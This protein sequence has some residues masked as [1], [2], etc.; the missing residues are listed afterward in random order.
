MTNSVRFSV[1]GPMRAWRDDVAVDL[2]SPQQRAVLA[3]LLFR[4]G[5]PVTLDELVTAVWDQEP[6]RAAVGTARTYIHR[7]R[8]VLEADP[9]NPTVLRSL[10]GGY[11]M[12][13]GTLDLN[14]F[15][16]WVDTAAAAEQTGRAGEAAEALD[17]ALALWHGPALAGVPGRY[18]E[19]QR[20]R[21][22]EVRLIT[23]ERRLELAIT[24]GHYRDAVPELAALV[25][26]DPFRERPRHLL[27]LALAGSGRR[28]EALAVFRD[29]R[30]LLADELGI[31]PGRALQR[32]HRDIL[33]GSEPVT[34]TRTPAETTE[35][36]W[37]SRHRRAPVPPRASLATSG[38]RAAYARARYRR[39]FEQARSGPGRVTCS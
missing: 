8:R 34:P 31:E 33:D 6:P 28:A 3:A 32:V 26:E 11:A 10:G 29:A 37:R 35:G 2:G 16:Q 22:A 12:P 15:Q 7:L 23:V 30:Q 19:A 36:T 24:L 38:D 1:L 21:L 13:A 5:A 39:R 18:A 27:M 20:S 4:A 14:D 25:G 9:A 17:R